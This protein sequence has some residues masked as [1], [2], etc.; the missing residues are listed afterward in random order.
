[1]KLY[2]IEEITDRLMEWR[3]SNASFIYPIESLNLKE[4]TGDTLDCIEALVKLYDIWFDKGEETAFF[5]VSEGTINNDD[6]WPNK[7]GY[8]VRIGMTNPAIEEYNSNRN[9][10]L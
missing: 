9:L 5:V 2:T 10:V 1:M 8:S 3:W 7:I 6:Y 4:G